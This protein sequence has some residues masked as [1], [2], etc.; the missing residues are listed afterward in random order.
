MGYSLWGSSELDTTEQLS[1][2]LVSKSIFRHIDVVGCTDTLFQYSILLCILHH[3]IFAHSE[4]DGHLFTI[5]AITN[6]AAMTSE[7][8]S[9]LE[10]KFSFLLDRFLRMELLGK[11]VFNL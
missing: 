10:H 3:I 8:K 1:H 7:C 6:N 9:C 2:S 11:F 5:W 4:A